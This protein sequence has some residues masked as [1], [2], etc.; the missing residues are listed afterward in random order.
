VLHERRPRLRSEENEPAPA[1]AGSPSF[2]TVAPSGARGSQTAAAP[3]RAGAA[4]IPARIL[5]GEG[6]HAAE[7]RIELRSGVLAGTSIHLETDAAGIRLRL[8]AASEAAHGA[9][10]AAIDRAR[11][12]LGTRGIVV[13]AERV[14]ESG[15]KV[16]HGRPDRE[17]GT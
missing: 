16:G 12:R 6:R 2:E 15:E 9:L 1:V 8:S 10:A 7:A 13:R 3:T 17:R 5:V 14:V 4:V 11:L